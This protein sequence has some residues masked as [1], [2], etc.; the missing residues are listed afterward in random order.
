MS[1]IFV[2][3]ILATA[4]S[5]P[6]ITIAMPPGTEMLRDCAITPNRPCTEAI[7]AVTSSGQR[8]QAVLTGRTATQSDAV[9]QK[10]S[11]EYALRG[12]SFESPSG[13]RIIA[14]IFYDG[15]WLQNALEPSWLDTI[16]VLEQFKIQTPK[17]ET[18]LWCGT[19]EQ[20]TYCYRSV[21]WDQVL[22]VEHRL[23][24]PSRFVVAFVN[25]RTDFLEYETGLNPVL[26]DGEPFESILIRMRTT[27][28]AQVLYSTRLTDP[29]G[30][31]DWADFETDQTISNV[32]SAESWIS[33][34]LGN[35]SGIP[36]VSVISNG[37]NPGVP[38]W[39]SASKAITVDVSGPH[40]RSNGEVNRGFF[41]ARIS[42]KLGNC[43]WGVDLSKNVVAEVSITESN[44]VAQEVM[45]VN[46]SFNGRQYILSV[47]NFHYSSNTIAVR[48]SEQKSS[49]ST[50]NPTVKQ[51][52]TKKITITCKK[53]ATIKKLT[54]VKPTCPKGFIRL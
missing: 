21:Q 10:L 33:G 46:G 7:Y 42:R 12:L 47:S 15:S 50:K 22:I 28:K 13:N 41:Q 35:C 5:V 32:Y 44:G 4:V 20:P 18:S 31:S 16:G 51:R 52:E 36:S 3:G 45:T 8:I 38:K 43:L 17:R 24:L 37:I 54:G 2:F 39:D 23:R 9:N 40:F 53:G 11:D 26:I 19:E 49:P 14:R 27:K 25:A 30:T 48:F 1:W 34:Q 6:P 29:L